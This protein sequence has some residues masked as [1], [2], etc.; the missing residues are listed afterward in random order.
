M[1]YK[2]LVLDL[3]GTL[4]DKSGK[5]T[6]ENR[7]AIKRVSEVGMCIAV[8]T[9]RS[10]KACTTVI[11]EL[12]PDGYHITFDGALV[13]NFD[14]TRE[15]YAAHIDRDTVKQMVDFAYANDI[16]LELFSETLY[17]AREETWSTRAHRDFF[18]VV[19][20]IMELDRLWEN[21]RII[22]GGLVTTTPVEVEKARQFTGRFGESLHFSWARTPVYP[23]VDF[24]NVL[25]P[26]V[27][28]GRALKALVSHLWIGLD[29]VIAIGDGSNDVSLL[30]V[31]GMAV[32][33]GNAIDEV[34]AIADYVTLDAEQNGVARAIEELVG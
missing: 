11:K 18:G 30:S 27:S 21:E 23:G 31:A 28:K 3:D 24:I 14:C 19:P 20:I 1:K 13:S 29:E 4:L 17:F 8:S 15:L 16:A 34:K 22:K 6:R 2:M 26:G 33:M 9:G 5:I 7:D 10:L 32:A 12:S 25:N